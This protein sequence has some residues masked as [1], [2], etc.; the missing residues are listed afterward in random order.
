MGLGKTLSVIALIV[1][2]KLARKQ[3]RRDGKDEQDKERKQRIREEGLARADVVITTYTLVANEIERSTKGKGESPLVDIHWGRIVLDE[4]HAVKN[5]KTKASKAVCALTAD[6]RWCVT[7][8]PLHNNLWD[9][10]SLMKFLKVDYFSEERFWK[11]YVASA[12]KK[13]AERL[14]LLM[15]NYVLRREKS[16]L[17]PLSEKPLVCL[18]RAV[19]FFLYESLDKFA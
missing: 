5:R 15:R 14:N 3:R 1:D 13:S 12:T 6:A 19:F 2:A 4:A 17:S 16:F 11:E 9:L 18:L 8:T 7:G 10:Y